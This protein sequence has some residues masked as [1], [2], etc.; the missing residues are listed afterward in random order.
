MYRYIL[1]KK[2]PAAKTMAVKAWVFEKV[3]EVFKRKRALG[4]IQGHF[5]HIKV[6]VLQFVHGKR[7]V[8]MPVVFAVPDLEIGKIAVP[9]AAKCGTGRAGI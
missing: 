1:I 5:G 2:H 6:M 9:A 4:A 3:Y 8:K 7:R